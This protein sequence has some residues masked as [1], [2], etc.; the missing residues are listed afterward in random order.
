[1]EDA[2]GSQNAGHVAG[3]A[4]RIRARDDQRMFIVPFAR[5]SE[6]NHVETESGQKIPERLR[7]SGFSAAVKDLNLP[8][9]G[10]K[11]RRGGGLVFATADDRDYERYG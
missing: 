4:I 11:G 6:F 8:R 3:D 2:R 5:I 1:M 9:V 10:N 7:H